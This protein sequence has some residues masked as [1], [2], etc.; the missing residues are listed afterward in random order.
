MAK[1]E[2]I[3]LGSYVE[4]RKA[5][6]SYV[7]DLIRNGN[8]P[9]QMYSTPGNFP[10]RNDDLKPYDTYHTIQFAAYGAERG[11]VGRRWLDYKQVTEAGLY[12]KPGQRAVPIEEAVFKVRQRDVVTEAELNEIVFTRTPRLRQVNYFNIE[13]LAV[14]NSSGMQEMGRAPIIAED[15]IS[16][17]RVANGLWANSD[18]REA[19]RTCMARTSEGISY[20]DD[21]RYEKL[22]DI[23]RNA[24][25]NL[26]LVIFDYM[27]CGEL[28][29]TYMPPAEL[30]AMNDMHARL[31]DRDPHLL[32]AVSRDVDVSLD[33]AFGRKNVFEMAYMSRISVFKEPDLANKMV[34]F[35]EHDDF[36]YPD[37]QVGVVENELNR[38]L[39]GEVK[40]CILYQEEGLLFGGFGKEVMSLRE[41]ESEFIALDK[42]AVDGGYVQPVRFLIA[43]ATEHGVQRYEGRY[44]LGRAEG[45]LL[46]HVN[47]YVED[48]SLSPQYRQFLLE[49]KGAEGLKEFERGLAGVKGIVLP[50]LSAELGITLDSPERDV[51]K[52]DKETDKMAETVKEKQKIIPEQVEF[53]D[54]TVIKRDLDMFPRTNGYDSNIID[55]TGTPRIASDSEVALIKSWDANV[56]LPKVVYRKDYMKAFDKAMNITRGIDG[57][58][59]G[60]EA[61]KDLSSAFKPSMP[62]TRDKFIQ[63]ARDDAY[64]AEGDRI[65]MMKDHAFER[66]KE[67]ALFEE[68]F[69]KK[70][71]LTMA[72]K[73]PASAG[74]IKILYEHYDSLS[75]FYKEKISKEGLAHD[76]VGLID[77]SAASDAI[78]GIFARETLKNYL[79]KSDERW[80]TMGTKEAVELADVYKGKINLRQQAYYKKHGIDFDPMVTTFAEARETMENA[81]PTAKQR[82][83]AKKWMPEE[84]I[85]KLTFKEMSAAIDAHNKELI[86]KSKEEVTHDIYAHAVKNNL[87]KEGESYTR[88]QWAEDSKQV[89]PTLSEKAYV[90]RY[91]LQDQ[92]KYYMDKYP[93]TY[94][95]ESQALYAMVREKNEQRILEKHNMP[96]DEHQKA[97]FEKRG[98]EID[99]NVTWLQAQEDICRILY[100]SRLAGFED[101][102]YMMKND[103]QIPEAIIKATET[104]ELLTPEKMKEYRDEIHK[105]CN[106]GRARDRMYKI[107]TAYAV[108]NQN[109]AFACCRSACAEYMETNNGS[110]AGVE[111]ILAEKMVRGDFKVPDD[112]V[113]QRGSKENAYAHVI[114]CVVPACVEYKE[115]IDKNIGLVAEAAKELAQEKAAEKEKAKAKGRR[116]SKGNEGMEA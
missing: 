55:V 1:V 105:A 25:K 72:E 37:R 10:C 98:V 81:A 11:Y 59:V 70:E 90:T 89:E 93:E 71:G 77:K 5:L 26:Q 112:V 16:Q 48:M 57:K 15:S 80:E 20:S 24:V 28:G 51:G 18:L 94:P 116:K 88:A 64:A 52:K 84:Q 102:R 43:A 85:D 33:R 96:C 54:G 62:K 101:S 87:V 68:R 27:L 45:G 65:N 47:R 63:K 44:D 23:E 34:S 8:A 4:R 21:E 9:W 92:V 76:A 104:R 40:V 36:R 108:P 22:S 14:G 106:E 38:L 74:Q 30:S 86:A 2:A 95:K 82:D 50:I 46:A 60:I 69:G 91:Q 13:Q 110:L 29:L 56:V 3:C 97:F 53:P 19:V 100:T 31:V 41:A 115:S 58:V 114:T 12:V 78:K 113:E 42:E 61:Q 39:P 66:R 99:S 67:A 17:F 75:P 7:A 6:S 73:N 35:S 83:Y 49:E 79:P 32:Q 107:Q 109:D 111:K 103:V